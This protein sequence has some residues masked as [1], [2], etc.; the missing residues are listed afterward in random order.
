[1][2]V[3]NKKQFGVWMNSHQ[4]TIVGRESVDTGN[5]AILAHTKTASSDSNSNE[6][7]ANNSEQGTQQKLF[8][9]ITSHMQNV[10]EIHVTGTGNAQEQFIN[11]LSQIPQYKNT[12]A[13][14]STSNKMADEKLVEYITA[15]FN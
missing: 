14:E 7:S 8:K 3:K 12:V 15:Q 9:E 1:M 13:K 6:N 4:A 2:S 10:D 5:F 11:Y